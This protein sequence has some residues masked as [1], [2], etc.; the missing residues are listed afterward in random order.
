[1]RLTVLSLFIFLST[2]VFATYATPGT[3]VKWT[4]S[5]LVANSGGVVTYGGGQY[6]FNDIV[7]VVLNDTLLITTDETAKFVVG[8]YLDVNGTLIID[9]PNSVVFTATSQAAG[10]NGMRID[11]S[12]GTI[13]KKLTLEYAISCRIL[14]CNPFIDRCIFQ[15]NNN[16][17]STSFGNGAIALVRSNAIITNCQFLNN[18]RAAI[19]S[20]SNLNNA[21]KIIGCYFFGNNTTNQNVPQI[22]LGA[23]STA[24][25]DTVKIINN[26]ILRSSTNSG[27][28][29]FLPI[30]NVYAV[31]TGNVIKNNRYGITTNGGSNINVMISYNQI[32][33]NNTQGLPNSGG[34]GIAFTGGN[35]A[36]HQNAIVTGNLIRWN[37]WGITIQNGSKPNLGNTSNL[38]TSD[39]GKNQFINNN[40]TSTPGI[41]LYNNS[42]D[43]IDAQGNYWGS[44]DPAVIETKIFHQPDN[45]ALGLVTYTDFMV[46]SAEL[47][48]FK[49]ARSSDRTILTWQTLN[50]NNSSYFDVQRSVDGR[51]FT[52]IGRVMAMGL[53]SGTRSYNFADND[54]TN[55]GPVY[56][57]LKQVDRDGR[58]K[59]S[60]IVHVEV[61]RPREIKIYPTIAQDEKVQAEIWSTVDQVISITYY[62]VV[63]KLMGKSTQSLS[64][65]SNIIK[66][67]IPE[68]ARG[69]IQVRFNGKGIKRVLRIY[70]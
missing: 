4:L 43:P 60:A 18:Q 66:L 5:D 38:D 59:Y 12:T 45:G 47:V 46:L 30:G 36:S 34:S 33:S 29:G 54:I 23:T 70:N 21:P 50:E 67:I 41:D 9:P 31:I 40:N 11:S 8:S 1:M 7:F 35:S 2:P 16:N 6:T 62:D 65:G 24:G 52:P 58:S 39:N 51:S 20:G 3:G 25:S 48:N 13:L 69:L 17:A 10:F 64:P 68:K 55:A 63:G 27:G 32:D 14:D 56:Y 22:N 15:Y 28:I 61:N 19:Q 37:L 26:Q 53:S 44:N 57:R 49:A 42:P